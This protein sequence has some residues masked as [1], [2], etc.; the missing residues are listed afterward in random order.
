VAIVTGASIGL[1]FATVE[2]L[3]RKGWRVIGVSRDPR[4]SARADERLRPVADAA[5]GSVEL[6]RAD[7]SCQAEVRALVDGL[8]VERVDV[9][10]HGAG[11]LFGRR[12][13]TA[14][15]HELTLALNHF[16]PFLLTRLLRDRMASA[17]RII[18][19]NS[20]FHIRGRIDFDDLDARRGQCRVPR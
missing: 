5:G 1:G 4:R 15:G 13:E 2:A 3:L 12:G 20:R 8:A 6:L 9:L 17:P 10:I 14:E 19:L 11:G 16:A 18:S 7:L